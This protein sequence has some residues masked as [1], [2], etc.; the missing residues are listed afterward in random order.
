VRNLNLKEDA[1]LV[2]SSFDRPNIF[3]ASEAQAPMSELIKLLQKDQPTLIY[4]N[5]QKEV[6]SLC[7][8][9]RRE[10][11]E[12]SVDFYHAGRSDAER[13]SV[14]RR[15]QEDQLDIVCAT[16]AFGMGIDKPNIRCV[17][18][19]GSPKSMETY[20]Q[21][22]GRAGRDGK[23]SKCVCF[24]NASSASLQSFYLAKDASTNQQREHTAAMLST[25]KQYC[26]TDSCRRKFICNY[27]GEDVPDK[28]SNCDICTS[29]PAPKADFG[30][31]ICSLV[32]VL[33]EINEKVL[34][35]C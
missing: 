15:F 18:H 28:C 24:F 1:L 23:Q 16:V 3:L 10:R 2:V 32:Q 4:S 5:T 22:A 20:Y 8:C 29:S 34:P 12:F 25:V 9:I 35:L 13:E 26:Q 27:F 21:Q 6:Q 30:A 11:K 31:D 17:Y 33:V 14:Q 19:W 7:D